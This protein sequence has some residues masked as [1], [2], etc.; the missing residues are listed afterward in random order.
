MAFS[1]FTRR[2]APDQGRR[3]RASERFSAAG[4]S[5]ALGDVMDLSTT[6]VRL[7]GSGSPKVALG[8]M[9]TI[10]IG[11]DIQSV[12]VQARVVWTRRR[13]ITSNEVG[14]QFVNVK[15]GIA[16]ALVQLAKYGFITTDPAAAVTA[17]QE[18]YVDPG[19]PGAAQGA[20]PTAEE[21][22]RRPLTVSIEVEDLYAMLGVPRDA[23]EEMIRKA[24][25]QRAL[26]VH[27]DRNPDPQAAKRFADLSKACSVLRDP[28]K[29]ARYDAML[30]SSRAA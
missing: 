15:R 13:G 2:S 11:S 26:T 5:C 30:N 3:A 14:L 23:D 17:E 28:E 12:K 9:V 10:T 16:A 8:E 29:R 22:A 6:G 21:A 7:R 25:H 18:P 1:W 24:Y 19:A 4:L 20:R 27:P